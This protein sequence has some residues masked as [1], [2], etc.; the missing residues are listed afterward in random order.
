[1]HL[2]HGQASRPP[3]VRVIRGGHLLAT[4]PVEGRRVGSF[5]SAEAQLLKAPRERMR[6]CGE[7]PLAVRTREPVSNF[8]GGDDK[9]GEKPGC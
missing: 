1:M 9:T 3:L 6:V 8:A 2:V 7:C 5:S 4:L